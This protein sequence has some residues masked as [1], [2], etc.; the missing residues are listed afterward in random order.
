MQNIKIRKNFDWSSIG[1]TLSLLVLFIFFSIFSNNFLS[2]NNMINIL[3][4]ISITGICAVG[5]TTVILTSGIDL[6]VGSVIGFS[7]IFGA[8]YIRVDDSN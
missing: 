7:S 6:S 3:R 5:M 2:T 1:I 4:Q 8:I